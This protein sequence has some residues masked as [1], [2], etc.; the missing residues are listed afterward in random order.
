[1]S[2]GEKERESVCVCVH[3]CVCVCAYTQRHTD[4]HLIPEEF[5]RAQSL[6]LCPNHPQTVL[7]TFLN[8]EDT[9]GL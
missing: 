1:V 6:L 7:G 2:E 3:A 5:A 8:F 9:L 4:T